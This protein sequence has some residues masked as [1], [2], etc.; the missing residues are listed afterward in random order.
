M[1]SVSAAVSSSFSQMK[2]C[3]WMKRLAALMSSLRR[4]NFSCP[5]GKISALPAVAT[6][7]PSSRAMVSLRRSMKVPPYSRRKRRSAPE[8]RAQ[9]G[10]R[11]ACSFA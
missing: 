7:R 6:P 9:N 10:S 2:Y 1:M 11:V 8:L 4:S 5:V 3:T